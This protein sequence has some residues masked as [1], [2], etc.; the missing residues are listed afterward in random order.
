MDDVKQQ[1][2]GIVKRSHGDNHVGRHASIWKKLL[3]IVLIVAVILGGVAL[4]SLINSTNAVNDYVGAVDEQ[5]K[6]IVAGENIDQP[7]VELREVAFGDIVNSKYRKVKELESTYIELINKLRNYTQTMDVH[8]QLVEKFNTG[9]GGEMNLDGDIL[10]LVDQLGEMIRSNYPEQTKAI[11]DV[12][13]LY[14]LVAASTSFDEI[15]SQM[16]K[17]LYDN[18]KWLGEEREAIEAARADFQQTINS[19]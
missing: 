2:M 12:D 4:W 11:A 13:E 15:S 10:G 3:I 9:I 1:G 17:V 16:N 8:N 18:D 19:L 5:Y 7:N 6:E 14:Q